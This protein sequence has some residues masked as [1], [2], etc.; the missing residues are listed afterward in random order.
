MFFGVFFVVV[1]VV[2][3][4][5]VFFFLFFFVL[6]GGAIFC[7]DQILFSKCKYIGLLCFFLSTKTRKLSR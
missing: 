1:V 2:V 5:V 7:T 6:L 3:V 4:V